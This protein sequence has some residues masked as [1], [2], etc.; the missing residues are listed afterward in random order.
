[1]IFKANLNLNRI[2]LIEADLSS[3]SKKSSII[4]EF[5]RSVINYKRLEDNLVKLKKILVLK[6]LISLNIR[7]RQMKL[8]LI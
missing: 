8:S 7:P 3:I 2:N 5:K 6:E 1:M 4:Q